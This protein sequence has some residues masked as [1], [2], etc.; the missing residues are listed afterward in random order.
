MLFALGKS[1]LCLHVYSL[2]IPACPPVYST[3]MSFGQN[4]G[5]QLISVSSE[6]H[7][8][9]EGQLQDY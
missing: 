7:S 1:L 8:T 5:K 2:Q 6:F 9:F 3:H 4:V